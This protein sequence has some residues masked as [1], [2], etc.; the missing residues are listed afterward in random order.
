MNQDPLFEL[1]RSPQLNVLISRTKEFYSNEITDAEFKESIKTLNSF[2]RE[3]RGFLREQIKFNPVTENIKRQTERIEV[4]LEDIRK[5]LEEMYAYFGDQKKE[6]IEIGLERCKEAFAKL[7]ASIDSIQKEE[8]ESFAAYSKAPLQNELMRIGYA[9]IDGKVAPEAF[10]QKLDALKNSLR[11]YYG[12]FEKISP[13]LGE[14]E[15]FLA[16]KEEIRSTIKEY[17]KSLEEAGMFFKDL[18]V[19]HIKR[20]LTKANESAEKLL[21]FHRD[22]TECKSLKNCFRCGA[23]NDA[24]AKFCVKCSAALP[25]IADEESETLDFKVDENDNINYSGHV[26]TELT[27]RVCDLVS[28]VKDG[29]VSKEKA[30]EDLD[31]IIVSVSKAVADKEK[32]QV[33]KELEGTPEYS[34]IF[35]Q[36]ENLM[37]VGLKDMKEGLLSLKNCIEASEESQATFALEQFLSGADS[38][39]KVVSMSSHA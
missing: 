8:S 28:F 25:V 26:Q 4:Y 13:K 2:R 17:I 33:P 31:N 15:Y 18:N 37:N 14:K 34:Q 23:E 1:T 6:H 27:K 9:L 11:M 10:K 5:S 21:K 39:S 30:L 3:L 12:Y 20:G 36:M 16:H 22:F 19:E 38:L 29:S 24:G 32:L 7:H 35:M